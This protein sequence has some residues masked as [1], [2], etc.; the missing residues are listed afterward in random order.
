MSAFINVS[1]IISK[2]RFEWRSRNAAWP[3]AVAWEPPDAETTIRPVRD[4]PETTAL[5]GRPDPGTTP[6]PRPA[7]ARRGLSLEAFRETT[8]MPAQAAWAHD[9]AETRSPRFVPRPR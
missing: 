7:T 1:K 9:A 4:A 8:L 6:V 5:P 2:F 3:G